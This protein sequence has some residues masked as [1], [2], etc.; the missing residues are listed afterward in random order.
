M[1]LSE[2]V[3][4]EIASFVKNKPYRDHV[5]QLIA[6]QRNGRA[7][8]NVTLSMLFAEIYETAGIRTS[9]SFRA[10]NFRDTLE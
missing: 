2:R 9:I 7:F 1:I 3:R 5:L 10:P 8:S 6:S 4:R